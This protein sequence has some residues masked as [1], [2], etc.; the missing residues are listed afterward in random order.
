MFDC[1]WRIGTA[2]TTLWRTGCA[3]SEDQTTAVV[4]RYL[5]ELDGNS[6]SEPVIRALLDRAVRRLHLLCATLLHRSY[7][8][9][10][11]P[12]LNL[13]A[14]E[15]LGAIAERLLKALR[16]AR[17]RTVRQLFALANQHMRWGLDDLARR[18]DE[19][20]AAAEL[21]EGRVPGPASSA[22]GLRPDGLRMLRAI[23]EPPEEEREVFDLVR[24]QGMTQTEVAQG[25]G[26]SAVTVKRR[27][28]R[29]RGSS[30]S[31]WPTSAPGRIRPTRSRGMPAGWGCS[32]IGVP[33]RSFL[34]GPEMAAGTLVQQLLD[35][36]FESGCSPEEVCGDCPEVLPEVRRCWRQMCAVEAELDA[37]FQVPGHGHDVD[38]DPHGQAGTEVPRIP[39][40]D[41]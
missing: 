22:S 27:L 31:I 21:C 19:Q 29:S 32:A 2:A 8:C 5:D 36:I 38:T 39:G 34:E 28:S 17:P 7:P 35:E 6:P 12:P 3:L 9:L 1:R 10:T 20:S 15:L 24:I 30:R 18:L 23:D 16:E 14:D 41:V 26:I 40:Y 11:R 33:A 25:L 37:L 4:Q 13:Q